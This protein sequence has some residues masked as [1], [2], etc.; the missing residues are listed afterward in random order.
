[1]QIYRRYKINWRILPVKPQYT[2]HIL[3]IVIHT[4]IPLSHLLIQIP[5]IFIH[6]KIIGLTMVSNSSV[7]GKLCKTYNDSR[8]AIYR[9]IYQK[10]ENIETVLNAILKCYRKIIWNWITIIS[11]FTLSIMIR[12]YQKAVNE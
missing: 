4:L 2:F 9:Q 1:M 3:M 7:V 10:G 11:F 8:L 12:Y 6:M 5:L